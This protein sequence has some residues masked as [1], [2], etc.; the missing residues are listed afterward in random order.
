MQTRY[1]TWNNE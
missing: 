1:Q